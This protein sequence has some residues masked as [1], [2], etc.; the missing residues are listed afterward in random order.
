M[1]EYVKEFYKD[2]VQDA[3]E[4][5]RSLDRLAFIEHARN[6]WE[7]IKARWLDLI[8]SIKAYFKREMRYSLTPMLGSHYKYG[9]WEWRR[10]QR[11]R[12]IWVK[13]NL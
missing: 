4:L 11:A 10:D 5:W 12:K 7:T 3:K 6:A 8:K 13:L 2:M 9:T 1:K